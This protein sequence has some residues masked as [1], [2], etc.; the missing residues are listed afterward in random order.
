MANG[1]GGKRAN[2][3]GRPSMVD[4]KLR[5]EVLTKSWDIIKRFFDDESKPLESKLQ[6]AQHLAGKSVPQNLNVDG[7]MTHNI[8]MQNMI[9]KSRMIQ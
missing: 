6:I 3:T 9:A 4:E 7:Q 8:F 5:A 2:Q 1:W